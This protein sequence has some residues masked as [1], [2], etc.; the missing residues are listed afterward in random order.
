MSRV[1]NW[2]IF[3]IP[4]TFQRDGWKA[5]AEETWN[6][7]SMKIWDLKQHLWNTWGTP[8]PTTQ[9]PPM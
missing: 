7:M 6:G 1:I 3:S 5:A 8:K 2:S 4:E 9:W